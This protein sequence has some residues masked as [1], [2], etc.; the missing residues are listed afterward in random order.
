MYKKKIK[1]TNVKPIVNHDKPQI[2][3]TKIFQNEK[4]I[5]PENVF[6]GYKKKEN[7]KK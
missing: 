7:K 5:K 6:E 4:K 3:L 2:D 1:T